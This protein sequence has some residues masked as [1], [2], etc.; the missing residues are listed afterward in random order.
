MSGPRVDYTR[1]RLAVKGPGTVSV[2]TRGAVDSVVTRVLRSLLAEAT[3]A[4]TRA[5]VFELEDA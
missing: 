4:S 2:S 1:A 3:D 5:K